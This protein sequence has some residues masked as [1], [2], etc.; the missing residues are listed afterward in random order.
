MT[1]H[2]VKL[3][4]GMKKPFVHLNEQGHLRSKICK[5][6][7]EYKSMVSRFLMRL[8]TQIAKKSSVKQEGRN[9][10]SK[11]PIDNNFLLVKNNKR[12]AFNNLTCQFNE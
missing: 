10:S 5:I 6:N 1:T 4:P 8:Q 12:G 7:T 9:Q 2:R 3:I 11:G